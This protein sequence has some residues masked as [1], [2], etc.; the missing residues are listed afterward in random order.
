[1]AY[2]P[3]AAVDPLGNSGRSGQQVLVDPCGR[4]R[5]SLLI[6]RDLTQ[7]QQTKI[8]VAMGF[9]LVIT[10]KS[11]SKRT[12]EVKRSFS[13]EHGTGHFVETCLAPNRRSAPQGCFPGQRCASR[14]AIPPYV[15]VRTPSFQKNAVPVSTGRTARRSSANR[16]QPSRAASWVATQTTPFPS[17]SLRWHG[18]GAV[19]VPNPTHPG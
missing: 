5:L 15:P 12:A 9:A 1:M 16:A 10:L 6:G 3:L 4:R 11:P 2:N 18:N 13:D 7:C 8:C 14:C 19:R 17:K